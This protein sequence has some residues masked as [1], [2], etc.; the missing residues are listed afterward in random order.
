[1][2]KTI[3]AMNTFLGTLLTLVVMAAL[4]AGG[5]YGYQAY[6]AEKVARRETETKLAQREIELQKLAVEN[7]QQAAQIAALNQEVQRLGTAVRLL[8]VDHRIGQLTVLSQQGSAE[9]KDLR[10][11][12]SF[13]EVD[14]KGQPLEKPRTFTLRGDVVYVDA[15][16]VKFADDYVERGD[17]MRGTAICL[18]RRIYGETQAP[19]DG[20]A[21]DPIGA[22]PVAYRSGGK[23]SELEQQIWSR[24]WE[25]ANDPD[26]ASKAG[27]RAAHGS[28]P[29]IKVMPGKR[30]RVLLRSSGD[31]SFVPEEGTLPASEP[32]KPTL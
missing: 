9:T 11:T 6:Y 29:F 28:A 15:L 8:K 30:Y 27:V 32:A 3:Q 21:I 22:Q 13:V 25:Y 7:R 20:F 31:L 16:V 26:L 23:P 10:T 2:L 24:F 18:F 14:E 17:P 4:G 12:I 1:M 19:N 5:W